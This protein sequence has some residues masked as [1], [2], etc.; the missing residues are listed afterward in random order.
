M[1]KLSNDFTISTKD[2]KGKTRTVVVKG[3][4]QLPRIIYLKMLYGD[5]YMDY[6]KDEVGVDTFLSNS[7]KK[8]NEKTDFLKNDKL[9]IEFATNWLVLTNYY[10]DKLGKNIRDKDAIAILEKEKNFKNI[11]NLYIFRCELFKADFNLDKKFNNKLKKNLLQLKKI[12]KV[13]QSEKDS[14]NN[15][16]IKNKVW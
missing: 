8:S 11:G 10:K 16:L 1:K 14:R 5:D 6:I 3:N 9:V 12:N 2:K 7:L 13:I 15:H 4:S